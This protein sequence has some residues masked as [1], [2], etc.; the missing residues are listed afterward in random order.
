[1]GHCLALGNLPKFTL[2]PNLDFVIKALIESTEITAN[3]LKWAE[4]RR[5]AVK[6]LTSVAVTMADNIGKGK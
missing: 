3:T 5:D 4:S 2:Q 6:A 1:M